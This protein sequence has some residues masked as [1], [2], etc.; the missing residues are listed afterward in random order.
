VAALT[1]AEFSRLVLA[2][3]PEPLSECT[4]AALETHYRLLLRWSRQSSLV[5]PGTLD[6]AVEAHYGES[7][8]ALPLIGDANGKTIVDIGSGA[9]FPGFVI[10]AARPAARVVLVE[11]RERKWSFLKAVA[12]EVGLPIECVLGTVER[13]LPEGFPSRVDYVTLRALKLSPHAWQSLLR[14]LTEHARVLIWAGRE[15]PPVPPALRVRRESPLPKS[16]WKR[17]LELERVAPSDG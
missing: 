6:D 8:A 9:G 7:L 14:T 12:R 4:I 10:A 13:S 16:R 1:T 11:A 5:G 2:A 3:S 15:E 17:I